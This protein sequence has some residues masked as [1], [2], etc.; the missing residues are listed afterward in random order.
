MSQINSIPILSHIVCGSRLFNFNIGCM[1]LFVISRKF[2][3][4]SNKLLTVF[5]IENR[6]ILNV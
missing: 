6:C 5:S 2:R 1:R 4:N 3:E